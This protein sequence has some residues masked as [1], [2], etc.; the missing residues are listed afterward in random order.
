MAQ[1][2]DKDDVLRAVTKVAGF[3]NIE[4]Q[5]EAKEEPADKHGEGAVVVSVQTLDN[6]RFLIGKNGQNLKALEHVLR[7]MLVKDGKEGTIV[8]DVNDYRK[9]RATYLVDVAKQTV[10][11]VRNTQKAEALFPMSAYERRI[12]HMELAAYPD[13]ATESV[14]AEPQRRVIIKPYP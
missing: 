9:S 1:K 4:C 3:M 13:I 7:A 2:L 11:R 10:A 6:A 8:L 5:I 12:V 14:G